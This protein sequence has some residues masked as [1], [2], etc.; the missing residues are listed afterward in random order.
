MALFNYVGDFRARLDGKIDGMM[1]QMGAAAVAEAK[2]LVPVDTG[3]TRDSISYIY[4]QADKTLQVYADTRWAIY[5]EYGTVSTPA[6]PF[7]RP[8]L[9][10]LKGF[11]MNAEIGFAN[12][13][14]SS[15]TPGEGKASAG[16]A[17]VNAGLN[18]GIVRR[19]KVRVGKGDR[20]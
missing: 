9:L 2:R 17:K 20:A 15:G 13:S 4:R 6:R 10:S 11:R 3:Q 1:N 14:P 12:A 18:R 8:A 5:V 7:L 16:N 19:T